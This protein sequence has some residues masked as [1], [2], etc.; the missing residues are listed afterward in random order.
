MRWTLGGLTLGMLLTLVACAPAS[1][2]ADRLAQASGERLLLADARGTWWR[3]SAVLV[4]TGGPGSRDAAALPDRLRWTLGLSTTGLDLQLRHACCLNGPVH[5]RLQPASA[6]LRVQ[7]SAPDAVIGQWPAAWLVGL[8]TP[9]NTLQPSGR[10]QL[11]SPGGLQLVSAQGQWRLS[12]EAELALEG[13]ASRISTL[14][15]LG[16][17]R[18]RLSAD[19]ATGPDTQLELQTRSGALVLSGTGQWSAGGLRFRGE[20]MAAPGFEGALNNLLN[21]VGRR[22]GARSLLSI[23]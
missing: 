17:Y 1:W 13:I 11:L 22:Q 15:V 14:P 5:V 9:W 10:V 19:A 3:G 18:V 16:S 23:G 6:G 20:A 4:L 7:L 2:L 12:G 21:I 8:G